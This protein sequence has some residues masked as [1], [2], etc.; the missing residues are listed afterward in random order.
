[1]VIL[2][3]LVSVAVVAGIF[4]LLYVAI[5]KAGSTSLASLELSRA[6][7]WN[8][9]VPASHPQNCWYGG[10]GQGRRTAFRLTSLRNLDPSHAYTRQAVLRVV[11][12]VVVP[13]PL[14]VVAIRSTIA[15]QG[16]VNFEEAFQGQAMERLGPTARESMLR[17]LR[18][19][20]T[21]GINNRTLT[22]RAEQGLRNLQLADRAALPENALD[23]SLLP[24]ARTVLVYDHSDTKIPAAEFQKLLFELAT[25]AYALE[26]GR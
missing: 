1:M 19:G 13:R 21:P 18:L 11:M 12:E 2:F 22:Y 23:P 4:G 10:M 25:V 26:Q 15:R 6:L 17:F 7:G 5:Q 16:A 20:H 8:A 9:V 24:D 14:G 3:L